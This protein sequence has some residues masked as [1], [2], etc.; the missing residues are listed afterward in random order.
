[1]DSSAF[2]QRVCEE[3]EL[4]VVN[5]F[6]FGNVCDAVYLTRNSQGVLLVLKLGT[7]EKSIKEIAM[8]IR[9]Y[10]KLIALGLNWFIPGLIAYHLDPKVSWILMEYCG[11]DFITKIKKSSDPILMYR[12]LIQDLSRVYGQSLK[13]GPEGR[14][15][16]ASVI[17]KV[18]EQYYKYIGPVFDPQG[19]IQITQVEKAMGLPR[20]TSCCFSN[21]DFTPDDVY[22]T[23]QG[24]KYSD[25]HDEVLGIPIMGLACFAG[26]AKVYDLPCWQEGYE[27]IMNYAVTD[28]ARILSLPQEIAENIFSL[29]RLLQCF[30]SARFRIQSDPKKALQAF[31]EAQK[32]L[33]NILKF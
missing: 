15:S 33:E 2:L 16:V 23:E 6:V 20:V 8:N 19:R 24:I 26:V 27:I 9:G 14:D 17:K 13:Q 32:Y 1:M 21:W 22:L 25:P 4:E 7:T 12:K 31:E 3:N 11:E 10:N 30:L 28:V 18:E 29:G 5:K